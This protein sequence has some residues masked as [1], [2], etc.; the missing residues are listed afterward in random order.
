MTAE[1]NAQSLGYQPWAQ[2]STSLTDTG[3]AYQPDP[4]TRARYEQ[5]VAEYAL[6]SYAPPEPAVA[7]V[8]P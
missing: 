6:G 3:D 8:A 5:A 1:G 7:P 2:E 4:E